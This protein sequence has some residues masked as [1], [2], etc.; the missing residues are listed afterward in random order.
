MKTKLMSA[1]VAAVMVVVSG[2]V[3]AADVKPHEGPQGVRGEGVPGFWVRPGFKV[4]LVAEGFGQSRFIVRDGKGTLY[5]S[6]PDLGNIVGLRDED[7]DGKYERQWKVV[8]GMKSVHG[9]Q[10]EGEWLYFATSGTVSRAKLPEA[11]KELEGI[12]TVIA[13]GEVPSGGGHWWRSVLVR[14]GKLWTSIGDSGNLTDETE[15]DRQKIWRFTIGE[16]GRASGKTLWSTGIR[17]T[18]KLMN[19]P[20]T[21]EVWGMDHGSDNFGARYG[22]KGGGPITD[23]IP[24]CEFNHYVQGFDYGHPFVTGVGL[25]RPEFAGRGDILQK[26]EANTAPAW[27]FGAHWAPN[28]WTFLE[29]DGQVGKRGDAVVTFH[30][31]WNA[32]RK[33]GYRVELVRFDE[34]TGRPMGSQM[35]VGTLDGGGTEVLGRPCDALEMGDGSV[36]FTDNGTGRVYRVEKVGN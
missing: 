11:G 30:G 25:P 24:P 3:V 6:Q 20:G 35:I 2:G 16:D 13:E 15:T 17:N 26:V 31:S 21:G 7:G 29:A 10:V 28:G 32:R 5:V 23:V 36:L 4:T 19:R 8:T 9:M 1:L 18:E 27:S 22:E 33:V 12:Q 14:E 34:V